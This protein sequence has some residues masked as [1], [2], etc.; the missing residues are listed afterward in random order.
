MG[1][2]QSKNITRILAFAVA[3]YIVVVGYTSCKAN[4]VI[5]RMWANGSKITEVLELGRMPTM[6]AKYY[7]ACHLTNHCVQNAEL[8]QDQKA[9]FWKTAKEIFAK[10]V[11]IAPK[12]EQAAKNLEMMEGLE[13][14][15]R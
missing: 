4:L 8:S 10:I 15:K 3:T 1:S 14:A 12:Y 11:E 9:V 2:V 13:N 6:R 7:Y 5:S